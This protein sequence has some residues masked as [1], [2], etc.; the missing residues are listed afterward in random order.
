MAPR[1]QLGP[2]CDALS[3][4]PSKQKAYSPLEIH[5]CVQLLR[6]MLQSTP[7]VGAACTFGPSFTPRKG[8][9]PSAPS[10]NAHMCSQVVLSLQ[11]LLAFFT[12]VKEVD[13]GH[14]SS[15]SPSE[16]LPRARSS[17]LDQG[18]EKSQSNQGGIY[19]L[20]GFQGVEPQGPSTN[21]LRKHSSKR[22]NCDIKDSFLNRSVL[23]VITNKSA[24]FSLL[25]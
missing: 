25:L 19:A 1:H 16:I 23:L 14:P 11:L 13:I 4:N 20:Q 17:I 9:H 8:G 22:G 6:K 10:G 18:K 7:V 3:L 5:P 24:P 2:I 21:S 15:S 12:D